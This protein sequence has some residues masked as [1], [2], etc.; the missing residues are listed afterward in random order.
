MK[1]KITTLLNVDGTE[2]RVV[3]EN[4]TDFMS[5]TDIAKRFNSRS[6]IVIQNWMRTRNTIE[7]LGVWE[8]LNND[9][10]NHIE[11]DV[12]KSQTGLNSFALSVGDW[13]ERTNS[14]G[15]SAK[16]G[17]YG[18][19]FAHRDIAFEFLSW[20]NPA[21]KLYVIREFQRL[22]ED[23]NKRLGDANWDVKRLMAR[24]NFHIH[25]DAVRQ[26]LVPPLLQNTK[27]EGYVHA[28]E[29]DL[30]NLAL[31]GMTAKEWRNANPE[32]KGN[33]R[34]YA[35]AE[36]LLVLANLESLNARFIQTGMKQDERLKQLNA[37]AIQQ[38]EILI[39][40]KS[41]KELKKGSDKR[42]N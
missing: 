12:I 6:E 22:K 31:F 1:Q 13:V 35:S 42:I 8:K 26:H 9:N 33:I 10:F 21:F 7:F 34:D 16:T 3:A 36:Q 17:R 37:I 27:Q 39:E 24:A 23:E 38:I 25:S 5:L 15:I 41:L 11:F 32:L 4:Q 20:L 2:I 19:T 14:L 30:L 28:S 29:A 18:G 40:N